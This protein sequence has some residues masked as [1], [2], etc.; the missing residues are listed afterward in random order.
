MVELTYPITNGLIKVALL[1]M[2]CRI[3]TFR[4]VRWAVLITG[5]LSVC[6]MMS[7]IFLSLAQCR[8]VGEMPDDSVPGV[9]AS[10]LHSLSSAS[11]APHTP[12]GWC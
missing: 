2:Y 7:G 9:P 8:M 10:L 1:M 12:S 6:L 5:F 11:S 4:K 3:F